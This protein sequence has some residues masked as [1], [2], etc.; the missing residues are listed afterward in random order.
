MHVHTT[1]KLQT[2][3]PSLLS[4]LAIEFKEKFLKEGGFPDAP[5]I[6]RDV[7]NDYY[8]STDQPGARGN[9]T[10]YEAAV[11]EERAYDSRLLQLNNNQGYVS[12][13]DS[14]YDEEDSSDDDSLD[15]DGEN[16][17]G[18]NLAFINTTLDERIDNP[19]NFL[20][21][22]G[23]PETAPEE[24]EMIPSPRQS[25]SSQDPIASAV[26]DPVVFPINILDPEMLSFG[27]RIERKIV[28]LRATLP[29]GYDASKIK[30]RVSPCR[31]KVL[32][33]L[34][35]MDANYDAAY[36]LGEDLGGSRD[37]GAITSALASALAISWTANGCGEEEKVFV[38]NLPFKVE[39]RGRNPATGWQR[40]PPNFNGYLTVC[41][42]VHSS[43]IYVWHIKEEDSH[44]EQ[45]SVM[46]GGL[47][48]MSHQK[49]SSTLLPRNQHLSRMHVLD[50]FNNTPSPSFVTPPQPPTNTHISQP[51]VAYPAPRALHRTP[52]DLDSTSSSGSF[53]EQTVPS[54]R[55]S[56][57]TTG[58]SAV[59]DLQSS[60]SLPPQFVYHSETP[61]RSESLRQLM[62]PAMPQPEPI[63]RKGRRKKNH[64]SSN[65]SV[66]SAASNNPRQ[67]KYQAQA[68]MHQ[69]TVEQRHQYEARLAWEEE[70]RRQMYQEEQELLQQQ[71]QQQ[72]QQ[73]QQHQQQQQQQHQQQQSAYNLRNRKPAPQGS[74]SSTAETTPPTVETVTSKDGDY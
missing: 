16:L 73:E 52:M 2:L 15:I 66:A 56:A 67:K 32:I 61:A 55:P 71:Q 11:R 57:T 35:K 49:N 10:N 45:P 28:A 7:P 14:T 24:D 51:C 17:A 40:C 8:T 54:T 63:F 1:Y 25:R 47:I 13:D 41:K 68:Q 53:Y 62:N 29:S 65:S 9:D 34:V 59:Y 6:P 5:S 30:V 60:A 36:V 64:L 3:T 69:G 21:D 23:I 26:L 4:F 18:E 42:E 37:G 27:Q 31:G 70:Q 19:D 44:V 20:Y 12:E 48:N 72:Q 33:T 38:I 74:S 46:G 39:A 22:N 43:F 58:A 50:A